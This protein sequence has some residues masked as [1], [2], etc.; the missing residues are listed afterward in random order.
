MASAET[1]ERGAPAGNAVRKQVALYLM[2][3]EHVGSRRSHLIYLK[4]IVK[5]G[6]S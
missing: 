4:R 6:W 1:V 3:D 5:V 2:Q